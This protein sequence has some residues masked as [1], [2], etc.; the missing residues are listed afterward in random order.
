[1]VPFQ[2]LVS[3]FCLDKGVLQSPQS[4]HGHLQKQV[5]IPLVTR[6]TRLLMEMWTGGILLCRVITKKAKSIS[7]Q[8]LWTL[9]YQHRQPCHLLV[10][11]T[12]CWERADG[13]EGLD[14]LL[15]GP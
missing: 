10:R 9:L 5:A 2:K 11:W 12:G 3:C 14:L 13:L 8:A 4:Y 6:R 15:I 1:M 7:G